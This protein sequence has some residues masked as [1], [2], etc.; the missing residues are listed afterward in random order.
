VTSN[1]HRLRHQVCRT[2]FEI[3][4]VTRKLSTY[5]VRK[6]PQEVEPEKIAQECVRQ[7]NCMSAGYNISTTMHAL[8]SCFELSNNICRP[9]LEPGLCSLPEQ[10]PGPFR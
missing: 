2:S 6:M 9:P 7:S 1:F 5:I 4:P 10:I 8:G 3:I